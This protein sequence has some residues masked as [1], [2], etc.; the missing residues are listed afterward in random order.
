MLT[1]ILLREDGAKVVIP[2]PEII[3]QMIQLI[4][5]YFPSLAGVWCVMDGLKV[6]IE[7]PGDYKMQ[8]AY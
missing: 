1:K 5:D 7:K 2:S 4:E 6:P 8:N 3:N